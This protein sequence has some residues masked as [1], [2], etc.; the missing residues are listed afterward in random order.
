MPHRIHADARALSG[1]TNATG[2]AAAVPR[3]SA[4]SRAFNSSARFSGLAALVLAVASVALNGSVPGNG[5]SG[6][7]AAAWFDHQPL[8]HV[9]AS[10]IGGV[11]TVLL[12]V[13]LREIEGR[14]DIARGGILPKIGSTLAGIVTALLLLGDAPVMAGAMTA[15]ERSAPLPAASAEVFL[16]LGIGIYLLAM[17]A[18]GAYLVVTC[19]LMLRAPAT[20]RPLAYASLAGGAIS[21]TPIF[22]FL[23]LVAV[24]PLWIVGATAWLTLARS[25]PRTTRYST[26]AREEEGGA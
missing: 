22:G 1:P 12:L 24:L 7:Q 5:T 4:R 14:L 8:R 6:A 23:G 15:H 9:L 2:R 13:F 21:L 11:A 16:H 26:T 18:L 25:G 17:V 20:A 3:A 10:W 19:A